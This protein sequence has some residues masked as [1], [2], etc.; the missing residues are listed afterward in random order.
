MKIY[1][2]DFMFPVKALGPSNLMHNSKYYG[3][4]NYTWNFHLHWPV[5]TK[6]YVEK[7]TG[8]DLEAAAGRDLRQADMNLLK[9]ATLSRGYIL[10]KLPNV[11]RPILE[12]LVAKSSD[13]R[14]EV[15]QF[16]LEILQTWGGYNSLYR[17]SKDNYTSIGDAAEMYF[18]G[19][20]L[21]QP[22]YSFN[23]PHGYYRKDY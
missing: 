10:G 17:V 14:E 8:V 16:Q 1:N 13:Y 6:E 15:L 4:S 23:I 2:K 9:I 18:K 3:D 7:Y 22:F 11:S 12:F 21:S 19:S 5:I 20:V